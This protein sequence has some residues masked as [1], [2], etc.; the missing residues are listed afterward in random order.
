MPERDIALVRRALD[1]FNEGGA[2][3]A[4]A[5]DP[6][7]GIYTDAP[8]LVPLRG[9]LEGTVYTGESSWSQFWQECRESWGELRLDIDRFEAIGDG[10]LG[11]GMLYGTSRETE[12]PVEARIAFAAHIR[13]GRIWRI[14]VHLGEAGARRELEGD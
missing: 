2:D 12:A 13:D 8:E 5:D 9:A 7:A 14:A 3:L 1:A 11:V 4:N 10:I 6:P